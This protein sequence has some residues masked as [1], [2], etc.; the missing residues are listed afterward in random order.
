MDY[1]TVQQAAEKWNISPRLVQQYCADGRIPGAQKFGTAWAIPASAQKPADPR[2]EKAAPT[3]ITAPLEEAPS[4][5]IPMPLLNGPFLPGHCKEYV[6]SIPDAQLRDIAW[7]EYYY[8]SGQPEEAARIAELYLSYEELSLRLSACLIYTYANLSIGQIQRAKHTLTQIQNTLTAEETLPPQL[9]SVAVFAITTASVLLH[10]PLPQG[11]HSLPE[12]I[13]LLPPGLRMFALY[14]QAHQ[15]Y[16][17]GDYGKSIGIVETAFALEGQR[18]PI[19]SIYL[20]LVAVMD[21]MSLK[22]PEHAQAHLLAAWKLAQPDDLIEGFGE[23]HGLL[24]GMLE[25]VLKKDWPEDFRRI[26]A[27]TYRFSAGWRKVHNP[28]TG[29]PV[30]DNLTTTEFAAA[31]LAARGWTNQEIAGHLGISPNTVKQYIST[32]LQKL[33][34]KQRK[35]LKQYMLR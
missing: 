14:V 18:Y 32:A 29:H 20:H 3:S 13:R 11:L 2:K 17:E 27:I 21:Y 5:P 1:I 31:M 25:A 23:H 26:I 15:T 7:A 9:Q 12:H 19:P 22:Q 4:H 16:L 33:N 28:E 30:A 34:I 10:L 35:D 6:E 24:G 8:F